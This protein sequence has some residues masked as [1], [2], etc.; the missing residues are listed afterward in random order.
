MA[1]D[2]A[3]LGEDGQARSESEA[4]GAG[5]PI[6][7]LDESVDNLP[8]T[9]VIFFGASPDEIEPA[10]DGILTAATAHG[11]KP[12]IVTVTGT[13][14]HYGEGPAASGIKQRRGTPL[15]H[16]TRPEIAQGSAGD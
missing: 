9:L 6:R 11:E 13:G 16:S 7:F 3:L 10:L 15:L 14:R 2:N 4:A 5:L 12:G 1:D 8:R